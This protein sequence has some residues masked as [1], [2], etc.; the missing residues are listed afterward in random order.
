MDPQDTFLN[1]LITAIATTTLF[2]FIWKGTSYALSKYILDDFGGFSLKLIC[3]A[4]VVANAIPVYFFNK[5]ERGHA[6]QGLVSATM[7]MVLGIMF[8][9]WDSFLK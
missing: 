1:G 9:F 6:L 4:S 3:I 5:Y 7:F 8:Y 2:F